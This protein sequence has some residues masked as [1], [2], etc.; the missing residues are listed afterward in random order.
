MYG[1][2]RAAVWQGS[3][4]DRRPYA[5]LVRFLERICGYAGTNPFPLTEVRRLFPL[6][7]RDLRIAR[8]VANRPTTNDQHSSPELAPQFSFCCPHVVLVR[9]S[10]LEA[11]ST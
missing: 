8:S 9:R 5:D 2:E 10:V 3:A 11:T 1:P 7:N 4:G 6:G